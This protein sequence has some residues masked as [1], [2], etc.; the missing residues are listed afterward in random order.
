MPTSPAISPTLVFRVSNIPVRFEMIPSM[1]SSWNHSCI[2]SKINGDHLLSGRPRVPG[3]P[4]GSAG[5][6]QAESRPDSRGIRVRPMRATPPPAMSCLMP[7]L[8]EAGLVL[9]VTF[10]E[11][12]AAPHAQ[13]AA[14]RNHQSDCN[15]SIALVKK[16]INHISFL[17]CRIVIEGPLLSI[18]HLE[19]LIRLY[20]GRLRFMYRSISKRYFLSASAVYL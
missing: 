17:R 10:Q 13:A 1:S 19:R 15:T 3:P 7:W 18:V 20:D 16:S 4:V 9:P 11:V 12:D 5:R 14:Q 6:H 2:A 8:L